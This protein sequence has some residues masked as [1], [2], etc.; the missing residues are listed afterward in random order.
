MFCL[1]VCMPGVWEGQE[2]ASGSLELE[3]QIRVRQ[4]MGARNVIQVSG[5][6]A[7]ARNC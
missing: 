1:H 3:L 4:H 6:A 7:R 2:R 5:R